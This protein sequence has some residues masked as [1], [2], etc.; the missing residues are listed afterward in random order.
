[1]RLCRQELTPGWPATPSRGV[2]PCLREDVPRGR[3]RDRVTEPGELALDPAMTP[4]R[5]RP[6]HRNDEILDRRHGRR[7]TGPRGLWVGPF[8]GYQPAVP[9]QH[10]RRSHRKHLRPAVP[11][12][13][14]GQRGQPR[15]IRRLIPHA[16]DMAAQHRILMAQNQQLSVLGQITTEQ[17]DQQ[18]EQGSD[19]HVNEGEEHPRWS[20]AERHGRSRTPRSDHQP[21]IR[22]GQ[23]GRLAK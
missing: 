2:D 3:V 5:V 16:W 1:V 22:A 18:A 19:D 6:G 8:A 21:N 9:G 14:P 12:N 7:A 10:G 20:Q 15:P 13:Q 17:H 11:G 23:T 4:A